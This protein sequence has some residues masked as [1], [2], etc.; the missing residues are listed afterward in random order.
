MN[1]G[2]VNVT[3]VINSAKELLEKEK[4]VSPALESV[5]ETLLTIVS[6]LVDRLKLN[7]S[8]S[9]LPPAADP[10]RKKKSR[11]KSDKKPGGQPG[12]TGTTLE[13]VPNPDKII[14][15]KIE[16][17]QLPEG[18]YKEV[19]YEARQ[20]VEIEISRVVTEY[21]AQVLEDASGNRHTASF[22]S[23]ITRPIQ[24]G[25]SVKSHAVYLSQFQLLPYDRLRDY[26][27]SELKIPVSAGS[28]FNFNQEAYE[29][30]EGFEELVKA[31]LCESPLIHTDETGINVNGK[32]KWLHTASNLLWTHLF[33]HDKRGCD[34]MNETGILPKFRGVMVHDN[35]A[36]YYT[37]EE[38][39]HALCNAHHLRELEGVIL[40]ENFKWAKRMQDLL[41]KM[42]EAVN[43]TEDSKLSK[44]S[45][46]A[47]RKQYKKILEDGDVETPPPQPLPGT[48]KR[49]R[50]KKTKSRNL[51]ERMR[52]REKD[53]LR[54]LDVS[55]VPFTNNLGEND[56]RMTKVQQKISGC[57]K[58]MG[59]ARIFCRTRSYLLSARKHGILPTDALTTLFKGA[60]P[61]VFYE[62]S[63]Q[64]E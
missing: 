1:L 23:T 24:Y 58:A 64:A 16:K 12:R 40:R 45:A 18:Q 41:K 5:C 20:V 55:T 56:I 21:R 13:P 62:P 9:S 19:G 63:N 46:A 59:G 61:D 15:L 29:K 3:E 33:P 8:N 28:L 57:F 53:I 25:Q 27:S 44:E 32:R 36:P 49:G 10:N 4:G 50:L 31:K 37:Y 42:N 47:F 7:S 38:C 39:D 34:A 51:L 22:P 14:P 30:L 26:F 54:F 52:H 43:E 35:W 60:L 48:K 11:S 17:D 2:K 6:M